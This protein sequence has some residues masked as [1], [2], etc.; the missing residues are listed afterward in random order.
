M[1]QKSMHIDRL[2]KQLDAGRINRRQFLKAATAVVGVATAQSILAACAVPV[3]APAQVA[4]A[5]PAAGPIKMVGWG[6]HPEIVEDNV[7]RFREAYSETVDYELTTGGN[8]HQIVETKMIGGEKP[9]VVYSESEYL[10]RWWKAGFVT[11]V[12]HVLDQPASFYKDEMYPANVQ[13][14]SLPDGKLAGLPYYSGYIAFVYNKDHLDQAKLQPPETWEELTEQCREL[15]SLGISENPYLSA[16]GHEWASLSWSIFGTW[17]SEGEPVFDE[18]NEPT[19]QD[20]GVAFRK[21]IEMHKQWYDEGITPPDILTQEGESVPTFLTGRHTFMMVHDYDQQQFNTGENSAVKDMIGNAIVPGATHQT[22]SWTAC[23]LMGAREVDSQRA[24]NLMQW[25]GGQNIDG[26][27]VGNKRWALETGLGSP[28]RKVMEDPDVIEAWSKWR[29]M[30]VHKQQLENTKGR[31]VEKT[32]WFPEWNWQ[33]MT[34]VQDY[35]QGK[36]EIGAV[37]TTLYELAI[38]LKGQYPA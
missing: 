7:N 25:L 24:W 11:D 36:K 29:D 9:W 13:H 6:Y 16:Q 22:F 14:L 34:E 38:K 35:I 10:Y 26:E 33:M 2:L 12:E 32:L 30:D 31:D 20:G 23:Y 28:H 8:Y 21:V 4:P 19:F 37:I 17:F 1:G 5:P 3:A 27:Y 18:N 15:K